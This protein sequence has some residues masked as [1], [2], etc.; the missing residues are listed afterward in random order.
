MRVKEYNKLARIAC[1]PYSVYPAYIACA[2]ASEQSDLTIGINST[3]DLLKLDLSNTQ[4]ELDI[5]KSLQIESRCSK[6]IWSNNNNN[7]L[8]SG[9]ENTKIYIYN[10]TT[11]ADDL[12]LNLLDKLEKHQSG[13]SIHSIDLNPFQTNLLFGI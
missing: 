4:T 5:A 6:L 8:I 11:S 10:T 13:S 9:C 1:S 12:N 2:T 7:L 3:I